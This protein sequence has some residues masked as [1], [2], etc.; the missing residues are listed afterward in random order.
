MSRAGA[1]TAAGRAGTVRRS[2]APAVPRR[3]SGPAARPRAV[4]APRP[5][6]LP[7]PHPVRGGAAIARRLAGVAHDASASWWMDRLVRSRAWIVIIAFGLIGIVAMQVSMLSLNTGI[8]RAVESAST[9]ERQ[10]AAERIQI[11]RLSSGERIQQVASGLGLVMPAPDE[12]RYLSA[13]DLRADGRRAANVMRAPDP[14]KATPPVTTP[15]VIPV[16]S[17]VP[18]T[19]AVPA[20][21]AATTAP[22]VTTPPS[23]TAPAAAPDPA[24]A[25]GGAAPAAA[26]PPPV[27]PPTATAP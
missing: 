24:P 1:A 21:A 4:P 2:A 27:P 6:L 26:A 11:S 20:A 17:G 7:A 19:P 14:S 13:G 15:A 25:S 23:T 18:A 16:A 3:V 10:N 22:P 5:R 8:G 12:V 9:L